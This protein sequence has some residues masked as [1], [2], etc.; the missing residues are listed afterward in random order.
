MAA[1][2]S[3]VLLIGPVRLVI[4]RGLKG[5]NIHELGAAP[6]RDAFLAS[7]AGIRALAVTHP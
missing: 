1:E 7:A 5:F 2:R 6:D 4:A 3:E